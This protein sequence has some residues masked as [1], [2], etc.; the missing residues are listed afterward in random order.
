MCIYMCMH[1]Y[2]HTCI[3]I[4]IYIYIYA[5]IHRA[6]M[7]LCYG[8]PYYTDILTI[9]Y[10][11]FTIY[12]HML[13]HIIS[14]HII[15]YHIISSYKAG[16]SWCTTSECACVCVGECVKVIAK[17]Y[18]QF[19]EFHVCFCGLDSGSL[20]FETVRTNKQHICFWDLRRSI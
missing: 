15:S 1:I 8:I 10:L 20:N 6:Y 14:Y 12:C 13:H 2:I 5:Y 16:T 19:S 17:G 7:M 11:L 9:H 4:Y 18:G 3:S